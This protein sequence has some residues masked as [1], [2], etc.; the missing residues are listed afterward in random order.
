M[1]EGSV[2]SV[3]SIAAEPGAR[4][5]LR[6]VL[7]LTDGD[8]ITLDSA[9]L[10]GALVVG[11]VL[12]QGKAR[13]VISFKFKAKTRYR[14]KRGHRQ[15]FTKIAVREILPNGSSETGTRRP[16][17]RQAAAPAEEPTDTAATTEEPV[18]TTEE[19]VATTAAA[20]EP[21]AETPEGGNTGPE[22]EAETP[23]T[24]R[25]RRTSTEESA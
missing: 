12:E 19:P 21:T 8:R 24:R 2:I 20:E 5:E 23:P 17:S 10:G 25:R 11:E 13:K 14:R 4:I 3:A 1:R 22:S 16:A 7:M 18:A 9:Q 6:D 15:G